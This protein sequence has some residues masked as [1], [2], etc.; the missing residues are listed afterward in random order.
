MIDES[1][2]TG[3]VEWLAEKARHRFGIGGTAIA[4]ILC[5]VVLVPL[6]AFLSVWLE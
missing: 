2:V 3:I 1:A 6:A 5:L 4:F